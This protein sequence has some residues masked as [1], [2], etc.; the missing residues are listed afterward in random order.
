VGT[1]QPRV[2]R[3]RNDALHLSFAAPDPIM[4]WCSTNRKEVI[5]C[6]V[7]S[8]TRAWPQRIAL[9]GSSLP[10]QVQDARPVIRGITAEGRATDEK[11]KAAGFDRSGGLFRWWMPY[12]VIDRLS[13]FLAMSRKAAFSSAP[14]DVS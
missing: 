5:R 14:L 7:I 4:R 3:V 1:R 11:R 2:A 13:I 6:R 9:S 10:D 8:F 12:W